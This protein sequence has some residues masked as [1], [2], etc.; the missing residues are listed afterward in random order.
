MELNKNLNLIETKD[1]RLFDI[2]E[3]GCYNVIQRRSSGVCEIVAYR[4]GST[5]DPIT[6]AQFDTE[7]VAYD[8]YVKFKQKLKNRA[9][10]YISF[11]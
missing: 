4:K 6:L 8:N 5:T 1:G 9:F 3:F 7:S 11:M 10:T 2:S